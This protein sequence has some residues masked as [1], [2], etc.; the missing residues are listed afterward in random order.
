MKSSLYWLTIFGDLFRLVALSLRSKSSLAAENLFLR[1][2]L[3][4]YR[5]R[6]IK[7]RRTDNRTRLTLALLGRWF[8]WRSAL[9]VV[10]PKTFIGWHRKGYQLFWRWKCQSGR[11]RIPPHLQHLISQAG[12]RQPVVGIRANC[13]RVAAQTRS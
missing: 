12:A 11:P 6:K 2:Q 4:F 13:K 1:K 10:T 5:E 9:A 3:A 7:P 8:D